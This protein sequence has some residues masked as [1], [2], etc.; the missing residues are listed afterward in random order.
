MT[1]VIISEKDEFTR[2]GLIS[3]L[4]TKED[5]DILGNYDTDDKMLSDLGS[6]NPD[7]VIL[8]GTEDILDRCRTCHE[9]R[10]L[11]PTTKVLTLSE[12]QKDDDLHET[13]LSGASGD[14]LKS[15]GSAE[16]V[17]SVSVV[18]CGGLSFESEALIRLLKRTPRQGHNYRSAQ[19]DELSSRE[20]MVLSLIGFGYRN[21]EI[22][23][24]LNVSTSTV[25]SDISRIRGKLL[26]DSRSALVAFAIQHKVTEN[27]NE[28]IQNHDT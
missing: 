19:L 5:I 14:V 22:G 12:N 8:G 17:N 2:L 28:L 7:V 25:K 1:T 3:A 13:I 15:S 11:C 27:L 9:V 16:M 26:I 24:K 4:Q 6:L 23:E 20:T 21:S 18:A 10:T